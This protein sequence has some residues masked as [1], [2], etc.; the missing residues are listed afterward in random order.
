MPLLTPDETIAEMV[1]EVM[2]E[3]REGERLAGEH[4]ILLGAFGRGKHCTA[5]SAFARSPAATSNS[6]INVHCLHGLYLW[7]L[8]ALLLR[9]HGATE[10]AACWGAARRV[11]GEPLA[12]LEQQLGQLTARPPPRAQRCS[13]RSSAILAL[14]LLLTMLS[15]AAVVG[16]LLLA[17]FGVDVHDCQIVLDEGEPRLRLLFENQEHASSFRSRLSAAAWM[18][19]TLMLLPA[20]L[21]VLFLACNALWPNESVLRPFAAHT[22]FRYLLPPHYYPTRRVR[23]ISPLYSLLRQWSSDPRW[24]DDVAF[25]SGVH[26]T[27]TTA[28]DRLASVVTSADGRQGGSSDLDDLFPCHEAPHSTV[29]RLF[30]AA[31]ATLA[32]PL[33]LALRSIASHDCFASPDITGNATAPPVALSFDDCSGSPLMLGLLAVWFIL[34][35]TSVCGALALLEWYDRRTS[36]GFGFGG[37]R[38]F[39]LIPFLIFG[40]VQYVAVGVLVTLAW[41]S[42][43]GSGGAPGDPEGVATASV[44]VAGLSLVLQGC[45]VAL[46]V[47]TCPLACCIGFKNWLEFLVNA[48]STLC[49]M[50]AAL[51]AFAT[52]T[53]LFILTSLVALAAA[54]AEP[55]DSL[56]PELITSVCFLCISLLLPAIVGAAGTRRAFV[57][58]LFASIMTSWSGTLSASD[59]PVDSRNLSVRLGHQL[60]C[61]TNSSNRFAYYHMHVKRSIK[62][63]SPA[64]STITGIDVSR[65]READ[66]AALKSGAM[67]LSPQSLLAYGCALTSASV[68]KA[69]YHSQ[70]AAARGRASPRQ[71]GLPSFGTSSLV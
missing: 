31:L 34:L 47:C 15:I 62:R 46:P 5:W 1:K 42:L 53:W 2:Q 50:G 18:V 58:S 41:A 64:A 70:L 19:L 9:F 59:D 7:R 44:I 69:A 27:S 16:V 63:N 25:F 51:L 20:V 32:I 57:R 61:C 48:G 36:D 22:I 65:I 8:A 39:A 43:Q 28:V 6:E 68:E 54:W 45:A 10:L 71:R 52:P 26:P 56:H 38:L 66:A 12:N 14:T 35:G 23:V 11:L 4:R 55:G 13:L 21:L 67:V 29:A 40:A 33:F 49:G 60:A 24:S 3:P 30:I 37:L 17:A